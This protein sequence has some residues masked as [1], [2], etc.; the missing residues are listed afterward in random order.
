VFAALNVKPVNVAT[1]PLAVTVSV[2]D[3]PAGLDAIVTDAFDVVTR[4]P[5]VSCT[6]TTTF[7]IAV[8]TVPVAGGSVVNTNFV[9]GPALIVIGVLVAEVNPVD[10]AVNV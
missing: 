1:P 6:C 7:P 2:P 3:T 4:L 10:M 5:S 9:A 8:F